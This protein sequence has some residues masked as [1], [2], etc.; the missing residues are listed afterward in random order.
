MFSTAGVSDGMPCLT[1]DSGFEKYIALDCTIPSTIA[2]CFVRH[3][4][5]YY[6]VCKKAYIV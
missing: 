2:V 6:K 5:I 1:K 4:E 3:C